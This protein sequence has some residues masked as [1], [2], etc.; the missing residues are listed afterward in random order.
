MK[1]VLCRF[2]QGF[3]C[4]GREASQRISIIRMLKHYPCRIFYTQGMGLINWQ[5]EDC[6]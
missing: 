5:R 4:K 3:Y 6:S 1:V 2:P